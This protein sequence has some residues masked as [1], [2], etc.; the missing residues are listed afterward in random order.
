MA[1]KNKKFTIAKL[2]GLIKCTDQKDSEKSTPVKISTRGYCQEIFDLQNRQRPLSQKKLKIG[3][4]SRE[5]S[6][7]P[8]DKH[9]DLFLLP[10]PMPW[11]KITTFKKLPTA[12]PKINTRKVKNV[13]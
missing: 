4:R 8:Q 5:F 6:F 10:L 1:D 9:I 7:P 12:T 3:T 2:V 13:K 11:R